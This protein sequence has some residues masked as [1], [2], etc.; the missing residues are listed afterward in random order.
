[1]TGLHVRS[2]GVSRRL[3][4]PLLRVTWYCRERLKLVMKRAYIVSAYKLPD[5]LFPAHSD[6][7]VHVLA[8]A[9]RQEVRSGARSIAPDLRTALSYASTLRRF[10]VLVPFLESAANMCTLSSTDTRHTNASSDTS[11][12]LKRCSSIRLS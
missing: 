9:V 8:F 6:G 7:S 4:R 2:R 3:S 1:M 10:S 11:M 5:Q 12:P